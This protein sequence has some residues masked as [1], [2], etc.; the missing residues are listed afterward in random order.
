MSK[1]DPTTLSQKNMSL[2]RDELKKKLDELEIPYR[3]R[4]TKSTKI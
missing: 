1:I 3:E 2:T 4:D